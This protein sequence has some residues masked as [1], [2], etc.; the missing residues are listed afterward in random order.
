MKRATA[1][2]GRES[3]VQSNDRRGVWRRI[4]RQCEVGG[5]TTAE[6]TC[7]NSEIDVPMRE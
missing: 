1:R 7:V 2:E 3:A 6:E 4:A 5:G